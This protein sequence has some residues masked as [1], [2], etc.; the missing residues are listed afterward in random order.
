MA[1]TF[2]NLLVNDN[3]FNAALKK[4]IGT[5]AS[6]GNAANSAKGQFSKFADGVAQVAQ[7]QQLLNTALKGNPYGIM[8]QAA[9][10]AFTKIVEKATEATD[11]EKRAMEW[12]QKRAEIEQQSNEAIGRST[13]ELMAK[14]ELLRV[15]WL[16]LRSDQQK[17][18]W[19]KNNQSAFNGLNLAVN[20]VTSAENV[21][22]NNTSNVVT[23]LKA[24]A[25]AEAYAELY[26]EQIKKNAMNKAS[27]KYNVPLITDPYYKPTEMEAKLAGF[28]LANKHENFEYKMVDN[29]DPR[30][31]GQH[32]EWTGRLSQ[33]GLNRLNE[34]RQKLGSAS[35][36]NADRMLADQYAS[37]MAELQFKANELQNN[38]LFGRVGSGSGNRGGGGNG[39]KVKK[40]TELQSNQQRIN[41]LTQEYVNLGDIATQQAKARKEAIQEEIHKLTERNNQL[42]L[43]SEQARGKYQGGDVQKTEL[44]GSEFRGFAA[45]SLDIGSGL[46]D[47][48]MNKL[49]SIQ[50]AG[51]GASE[52]WKNASTTV[53]IFGNAISAIKDPAAQIA[54]TVAQAIA[55]VALAYSQ[56]LAQDKTTKSN[57]WA[58]IAAAAA[59]TVSMA[60]TI[61]SIHSATGY[62]NGGIVKGNSYSGDN[63]YGGP[64]AMVNAGELVL[65]K[66]QQATLAQNLQGGGN[67]RMTGE[68]RGESI[69]LV[70]NRY[71]KRTGQG[72]IVTW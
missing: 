6:L 62:Q 26:K 43:Y 13:G 72:E 8:A 63:I 30:N 27:G 21:F 7:S 18:D 57:I 60:T 10:F 50:Q 69:V 67:I 12:T 49:R 53:G 59:A 23:A 22:V 65:T 37:K 70:A 48:V 5:F 44:N 29:A 33:I 66:A 51:N 17:I 47:E 71:F 34:N 64:D 46:S 15:Q 25:E 41:E 36:E 11:A 39:G 40:L 14:Y 32:K 54:A 58:F 68:I 19:I 38:S 52:A 9:T 45:A 24:R 55:S 16:N 42:K 56:T 35:L 61:A 1:R 20:D 4:T 3:G 2:V 31:P 28:T